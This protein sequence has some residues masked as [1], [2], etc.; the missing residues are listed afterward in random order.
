MSFVSPVKG[1]LFGEDRQAYIYAVSRRESSSDLTL[2]DMLDPNLTAKKVHNGKK[3]GYGFIGYFQFGEGAL[4]DL[5]YFKPPYTFSNDSDSIF[6]KSFSVN[7]WNGSWTG[8]DDVTSKSLFLK[9]RVIQIKAFNS[10][11]NTLCT[12]LNSQNVNE[13]YGV[14]I[15]GIEITESGCIA[16]A[17]LKGPKYVLEFV[18]GVGNQADAFGTKVGEYI[19]LFAHYDLENCCNRKVYVNVVDEQGNPVLEKKIIVE[20]EYKEG[21]YYSKVGKISNDYKTNNEGKIPVIVR[22]PSTKIKIIV[23]GKVLEI[24]QKK[25]KIESYTIKLTKEVSVPV[26]LEKNSSPKPKPQDNKTPQEVRNEQ[27]LSATEESKTT[28]KTDVNFNIQIIEADTGKPISNMGFF[29]TYKN[30]IK[31]HVADGNGIKQNIVAE[32]G[33]DIEVSVSGDGKN[34]KIHHFKVEA[35]LNNQTIKVGLPVH[36]FQLIVKK[37]DQIVPNTSV[38][39]FYRGKQ[40]PKKTNVAGVINLKM[41]VGFVYGFGVGSKSLVK[42]RVINGSPSRIFRINEGFVKESKQ[43]DLG[44]KT[45]QQKPVDTVPATNNPTPPSKAPEV[46]QEPSKV[47]QQNTHTESGGKPLTTVSNQTPTTSDTTRYHIYSDGKI[48]RE[49]AAATGIAEY[50]YYDKSGQVHN[51]GKTQFIVAPKRKSGNTE[52]GG[53]VY[54]VDQRKLKSYKSKDGKVG[55]LWDIYLP[56]RTRYYLKGD[57]F[58]AVIGAMCSLGYGYYQGSGFSDKAGRSVGSVSHYNGINGDFRYLGI[59]GCH[60]DGPVLVSQTDRFDWDANLKFVNALF[61]FGYKAF[62]SQVMKRK[63][64][65]N[66][67]LPH[68]AFTNSDHDNHLH[69]QGYQPNIQDI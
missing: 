44:Q 62:G 35:S 42:A 52:V 57:A 46:K 33:Q 22:H 59:S 20:S 10:W 1:K 4:Y 64:Q 31:K 50:I 28:D 3:V 12:R 43:F 5:G 7:D 54:L 6:Q 21:K 48:K 56:G 18:Q 66:R 19:S 27:T 68:S 39:V 8:L 41:L 67:T 36:S 40:I 30:N 58:A 23:D 32:A 11:I 49:N 65:A 16:G 15:N 29:L 38:T 45:A 60:K 55:Y 24:I 69:L 34:Q 9:D 51:I 26:V 25:D 13:F 2:S 17:H 61:L 63:G 14:R 47:A 37:D 53:N